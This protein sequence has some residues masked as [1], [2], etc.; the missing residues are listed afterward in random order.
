MARSATAFTGRDSET[1]A[2]A[3]QT[4]VVR[5]TLFFGTCMLLFTLSAAATVY[6]CGSMPGG[7]P[8]PGGWTMSMAWMRMPGQ[9]WIGAAAAFMG[10]WVVMM[11][12]MMLPALASMLSAWRRAVRGG[13]AI[14]LGAPTVIAG[15]GY[16]LVWTGF[17]AAAY[18]IGVVLGAAEMRWS[19]FARAVPVASGAALVL[20][21]CLQLTAWK[22]RQL[23]CCRETPGCGA[24]VA[25][26]PVSAWGHGLRLGVHCALCC[27]GFMVVLLV[28]GV[29]DLGVMALVAAGITIERLAPRPVLAARAAGAVVIAVGIAVIAR[30]LLPA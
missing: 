22:A 14:G 9:S 18:P 7:M 26:T 21:G 4:G 13:A 28:A 25:P 24:P 16:F 12:A 11:V 5:E 15:A 2:L 19:A 1:A 6:W 30:A 10:M 8:M 20:A 3:P 27:S 29:M 17:G 23:G